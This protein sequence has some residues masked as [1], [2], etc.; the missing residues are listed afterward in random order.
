M[1]DIKTPDNMTPNKKEE[2]SLEDVLVIIII[3]GMVIALIE[4]ITAL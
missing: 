3:I 2:L 4:A 1:T